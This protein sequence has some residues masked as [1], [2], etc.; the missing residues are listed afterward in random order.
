M[1]AVT[2]PGDVVH[3]FLPPI[4]SA[5]APLAALPAAAA[6]AWNML[7]AADFG[8]PLLYDA[9]DIDRHIQRFAPENRYRHGFGATSEAEHQALFA[10]IVS[11][12]N[13]GGDGLRALSYRPA[14]G[15]APV[16]LLREPE[17][18]HL[19]HVAGLV[20]QLRLAG[21]IGAGWLLGTVLLLRRH[22]R[23][24]DR[25]ALL[26]GG[27]GVVVAAG[28]FTWAG[29]DPGGGFD[30]LHEWVFPPGHQWFFYYQESLMTTLMKAPHLFGPMGAALV[31]L[32]LALLAAMLW[33]AWRCTV[34]P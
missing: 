5:L 25:R 29:F 21:L 26:A 22:R 27:A 10:A 14:P 31:L 16:A 3:R 20:G 17:I 15:A 9:L 18:V 24:L 28:L 13:R 2:A 12:I 19:E 4:L 1:T 32:T 7:S 8:Y 30:R 33:L 34:R 23:P 11:A 6:L